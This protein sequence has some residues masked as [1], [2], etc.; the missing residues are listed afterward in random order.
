M[1]E[2][3]AFR[4]ITA[5]R[6]V[7]LHPSLL[8][9]IERGE[10]HLSSLVLLRDHLT[11]ATVDEL[12]DAVSGKTKRE[13]EELLARRAPRA[14]V[15]STIRKLPTSTAPQTT[16]TLPPAGGRARI[17]P[18]S[19]ARH[20]LQVT[21]S[22]E[23]R[24]KLE[25]ARDLIRHRNPS[26]DLA[27]VVDRALDALLEKLEKETRG[28]TDRPRRREPRAAKPGRVTRAVRDQVFAR[29]GAQCTFVDEQGRR[30]PARGFLELDHVESR[31][32][33]GS[34]DAANMRVA[35]RRHNLLHAEQ[36]FGQKYVA[37]R[38]HFRQRKSRR[39][40]A[41]PSERFDRAT[42]GL[43]NMGFRETEARHALD[44]VSARHTSH[45]LALPVEE[46]LREAL[47]LLT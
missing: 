11:D 46:I 2:G 35:C 8:G 45:D 32:L 43:V 4:R 20:K 14:D 1:S 39:T 13:V 34:D 7:R 42:R 3:A 38:I 21:V 9:R 31:A 33:G 15:P 22:T 27:V 28:K 24:D 25:R 44:V 26:G 19:E 47:G 23:L 37:R 6:L 41:A 12:V 18:L 40:E 30:C 16:S 36:V 5:A 17:E 29:D 10:I